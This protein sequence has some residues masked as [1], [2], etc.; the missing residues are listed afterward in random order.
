MTTAVLA[1]TSLEEFYYLDTFVHSELRHEFVDGVMLAMTGGSEKHAQLAGRLVRQFNLSMGTSPCEV[2]SSDLKIRPLKYQR[3]FY[4]DVVVVCGRMERDD[5]SDRWLGGVTNPVVIVEVLSPS[6]HR[7]DLETKL[8][9][10]KSIG[11][12]KSILYV[13]QQEKAVEV[14]TRLPSGEW[15]WYEHGSGS[16]EVLGLPGVVLD[17]D[18]LYAGI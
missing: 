11:S 3:V 2:L 8:P 18:G 9:A 12:L 4:P 1:T 13:H 16:F 7:Y 5:T 17:V 15:A 14:W 6:T 10:Y